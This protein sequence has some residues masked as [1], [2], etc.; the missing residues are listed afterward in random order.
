MGS[1]GN[2]KFPVWLRYERVNFCRVKQIRHDL[3]SEHS[4]PPASAGGDPSQQE[5]SFPHGR[6]L[7]R[8]TPEAR[9]SAASAHVP[10]KSSH[11]LRV[12]PLIRVASILTAEGFTPLSFFLGPSPERTV[13]YAGQGPQRKKAVSS[14]RTPQKNNPKTKESG[15]TSPHSKSILVRFPNLQTLFTTEFTP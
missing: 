14:H 5:D 8:L 10:H 12:L 11:A 3:A 9:C 15:V 2:L 6:D 7:P 1:L 13:R 4:E